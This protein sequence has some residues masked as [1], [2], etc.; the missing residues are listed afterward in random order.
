MIE[1]TNAPVL[2]T[3]HLRLRAP[4]GS[5]WPA[6]SAFC[7][8]HRA[9]FVGGGSDTTPVKAWRAFGHIIGHWPMRSFGLFVF[10][11][12]DDDTPL[13]MAGPWYPEGCGQNMK[14]AGL[15]GR[16]N[17]KAGV[18]PLK[19]P[20]PPVALPKAISVGTGSSAIL[21]RGIPGPSHWRNDWVRP[22]IR[23]RP[24]LL[25]K[26]LSWFSVIPRRFQHER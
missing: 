24:V 21:I 11:L 18:M 22:M 25:R 1:L 5:D 23:Q 16:Q 8:S 26:I 3:E 13:G 12:K 20:V 15:S 19:R 4:R 17:L 9:R 7:T 2:E 14:S 6:W 10:T